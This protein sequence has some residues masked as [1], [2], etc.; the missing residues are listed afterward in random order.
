VL[1]IVS[2]LVLWLLIFMCVRVCVCV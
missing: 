1:L 2:I